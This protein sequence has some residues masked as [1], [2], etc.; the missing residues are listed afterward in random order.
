MITKENYFEL[1]NKGLSQSK[2]KD[3]LKCPNYF[4]RKHILGTIEKEDKECF[5]IGSTVDDILTEKDSVDNYAVFEGDRR[6]KEGKYDYQNLLDAGKKIIT[7]QQYSDIINI[8]DAVINTSAYKQLSTYYFQEIIEVPSINLGEHFDCLYGKIDCYEIKE[9]GVCILV[10]I[11]TTMTVDDRQFF[12]KAQGYGYFKQMWFYA[13]LLKSKYPEIKSFK[14][15]HLAAE[16]TE[17]YRVKL[18]EIP[19]EYINREEDEMLETIKKIAEDKTFAK[20]D[21]SFERPTRLL[22]P[23]D[24]YNE[25]VD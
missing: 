20:Q 19:E 17:P 18:Y 8:S 4:Y 12:Y 2:I 14:F 15:Y 5:K 10:D 13:Y 16:T 24:K 11:K 23:K 7:E 21:A 22:D 3:Y 6:T 25:D 9:D 1:N